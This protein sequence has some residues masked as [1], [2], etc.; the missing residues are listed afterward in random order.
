L[1]VLVIGGG[2]REH[3]LV[4]AITRDHGIEVFCAPGNAGISEQAQVVNIKADD[5]DRLLEFA[6]ENKIDFTIVGPEQPLCVGIVDAFVSKGKKI[7]GPSKSAAR[8][9]TSKVF[10]KQFMKR[11]KIPTAEFKTFTRSDLSALEEYL[12]YS[13]YPLVL[14]ADGLAAGKG[15][16]VVNS[17]EE[18][19]REV[20]KLFIKK[21]FGKS[22]ENIVVEEFMK[23][24]EASV[25]A[26]TDG[27]DYIVLPV[28]QDH[29]RIGDGDTGKNTGGMGAFAPTPF[30]NE[31]DLIK[32]K[33]EVIERVLDGTSSE[34]FP[35][36]GCLYCGM[37]LTADGPKVVEFN[38]RFGDPETQV[39][40]QLID[41]SLT[42]LLYSSAT[43]TVGS[44]KIRLNSASAVCVIASSKGYP[45]EYETGKIITGLEKSVEG[46][47]VF[48]SGSMKIDGRYATAGGRVLGVTGIDLGG[49]ISISAKLAYERLGQINF[50]GIYYRHDIAKSAIDFENR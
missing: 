45:D 40:L 50:E 47:K 26:I 27:K 2:G 19:K 37:M 1:R 15:V 16:S 30:V 34:G 28:A 4:D 17:P 21:I 39:V 18:A 48:H 11:W 24:T 44:H 33:K 3:A 23:G 13:D 43:K 35:Y 46:T 5:V 36:S 6:E 38:A 41:S 8:L 12:S 9:E 7:F 20:E 31:E 42:E 29:K 22:G 10:A 49:R 25:F 14:K 32:I